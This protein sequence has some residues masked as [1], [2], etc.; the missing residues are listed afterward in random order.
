MLIICPNCGTTNRIP[1][2]KSHTEGKCGKCQNGL[3]TFKPVVLND[4]NFSKYI[5]D[6]QLPVIVDFWAAWCGPCQS[7]A[8]IYQKTASQSERLLFAKVN[9]ELAPQTSALCNIRSIPTLIIFHQG[10]ELERITGA[11]QEPQLKQWIL[12]TLSKA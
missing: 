6:N 7:M 8:P 1:E 12:Q 10:R 4:S 2:D 9:T 11:L 5:R 3:H